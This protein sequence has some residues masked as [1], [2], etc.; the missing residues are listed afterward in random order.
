[1]LDTYNNM[2]FDSIYVRYSSYFKGLATPLLP[3]IDLFGNRS[4]T[5]IG[6]TDATL[7][8]NVSDRKKVFQCEKCPLPDMSRVS[9]QLMMF[10]A[11]NRLSFI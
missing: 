10:D 3:F 8:S 1:M 4:V 2:V 5:K 9:H 7:L 11:P 6:R